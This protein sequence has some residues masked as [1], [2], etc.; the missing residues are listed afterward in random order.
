MRLAGARAYNL[1]FIAALTAAS[2]CGIDLNRR[3]A[4]RPKEFFHE[5]THGFYKW[6]LSFLEF[7]MLYRIYAVHRR[8]GCMPW[9]KEST[10]WRLYRGTLKLSDSVA[11]VTTDGPK[12]CGEACIV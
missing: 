4:T 5:S 9:K 7:L 6:E 3:R 12:E 10:S 2:T 8:V 11:Q 1:H